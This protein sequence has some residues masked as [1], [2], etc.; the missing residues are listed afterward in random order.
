MVWSPSLR[1]RIDFPIDCR[2]IIEG[3]FSAGLSRWSLNEGSQI[4]AE[5]PARWGFTWRM[6][7]GIR[8]ALNTQVQVLLSGGYSENIAFGEQDDITYKAYPLSVGLR[9]G[10]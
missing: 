5:D 2:W 9:G 3:L 8:Y 10:F 7:L 4:P 6:N 1:T